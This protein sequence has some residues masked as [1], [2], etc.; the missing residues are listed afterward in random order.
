MRWSL[1]QKVR[2]NIRTDAIFES[3]HFKN[4]KYEKNWGKG[5]N[6]SELHVGDLSFECTDLSI[7]KI[8]PRTFGFAT[9]RIGDAFWCYIKFRGTPRSRDF[10][11]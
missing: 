8:G 3:L 10:D 9:L 11:L 2:E 1:Q 7:G 5:N 6:V 4:L